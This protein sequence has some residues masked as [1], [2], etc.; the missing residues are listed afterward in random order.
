MQLKTTESTDIVLNTTSFIEQPLIKLTA[1]KIKWTYL[2]TLLWILTTFL[3]MPAAEIRPATRHIGMSEGLVNDFVRK[4]HVDGQ[5][6]VWVI[7]EGGVSVVTGSGCRTFKPLPE[8]QTGIICSL[9]WHTPTRS[10]VLGAEHG[11][12]V[13]LPSTDKA[14]W[15]STEDG[16]PDA[17][18]ND[19]QPTHGD[20]LWLGFGNGDVLRLQ[21]HLD[22]DNVPHIDHS[23]LA[24]GEHYQIRCLMDDG[25]GNLYIGHSQNGMSVVSIATGATT[26]YQHSEGVASSLPG[27]NVR[28]ILCDRNGLIW[29][30]TD[31]GLALFDPIAET[32]ATV[33][34]P[35]DDYVDNV[36]DICHMSNNAIL[37]ATDIGGVK[38]LK[39]EISTQYYTDT[40]VQVSS[41]NTR[42]I[43][44]D[45]YGNAWIGCYSSGVDFIGVKRSDFL[46][47]DY[48]QP[49]SV[50]A[51]DQ[52]RDGL[53]V[54]S[55]RELTIWKDNKLVGRWDG[56]QQMRREYVAARCMMVDRDGYVWI[57]I[58]DVGAF[59]I[60]LDRN[61]FE[62]IELNAEGADIHSFAQD[63]DG[64]IW[65][66]SESGIF[67]YMNG[68]AEKHTELS[69][70]TKSPA[71]YILPKDGHL[72]LCTYGD[73]VYSVDLNTMTNRHLSTQTG[74][75]SDIVNQ[76]VSDGNQGMWL[77]TNGGLVRLD[78]AVT[79]RG[80]HIY[81]VDHGLPDPYVQAV[82]TDSLNHVW[83]TTYTGLSCLACSRVFYNFQSQDT[84]LNGGFTHGAAVLDPDG[85]IY[86]GSASGACRVNPSHFMSK[87]ILSDIQIVSCEACNIPNS[88]NDVAILIPDEHRMVE[89]TYDHNTLRLAY[90]VRNY[91]QAR[92]IDYSYM[93]MG[94]EDKW[95][96]MGHKQEVTFRGL[97]PG[98]YTFLVRA[99]MRGQDNP[100]T[101]TA[102][103]DIRVTPPLWQ[104]WW[105]YS[106]YALVLIAIISWTIIVYK[107]RLA[108]K[109]SLLLERHENLQNKLLNEERMRFYTNITHELRTPLTLI[110]GPLDDLADD[111]SLPPHCHKRVTMI[112][113]SAHRLRELL[114]QLLDFRKAETQNRRL[115][116]AKGDIGKFVAEICNNFQTLYTNSKVSF[117]YVIGDNLPE[118]WFDSEIV[119]SI[120]NN[121]LSNAIKYTE[122]GSILTSVY[123]DDSRVTI[124][125]SD[126]GCGIR[127]DE[128]PHIF[129]RYYQATSDRQ[130]SGTGIGL[131]LVKALAKLHNAKLSV[132]SKEG[133]GSRFSCSFLTDFRYPDALHKEDIETPQPIADEET[134]LAT[135]DREVMPTLLIVED[136]AD[137]RQYIADSFVDDYHILQADNGEQGLLL[138][139]QHMPDIIVS[140]IMMPRLNGIEMTRRLKQ[141]IRTSHIPIIILTAKNTDEDKTEGYNCGADSYLTKPFSVNLLASR[142]CNLLM[143]RRRIAEYVSMFGSILTP[144][145]AETASPTQSTDYQL[146][147]LDREFLDHLDQMLSDN[148]VSQDIDLPFISDKMGMSHSSFYRKV[149]ALTGLTA[150]EYIRKFKLRHC[151][152]LLESGDYN[153]NQAAMMTGFNQMS[154]FRDI[155][156]AEFGILPSEVRKNKES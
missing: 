126:T 59:R 29:V 41:L 47:L 28:R 128:L 68:K 84:H 61:R 151:Y 92:Q 64:R 95:Y 96:D 93:L 145:P 10:M 105:A 121:F 141:D 156:K 127:A 98:R 56:L 63:S 62:H 21:I 3:R 35:H 45:D 106:L 100:E 114:C 146:S 142:I 38:E 58:D 118:I 139:Q 124:S 109:S 90:S 60:D 9:N 15:F 88:P 132:D 152:K 94:M 122:Q 148:M 86:F 71:T 55:L 73:G 102:W 129:E 32:F 52:V 125:V 119:T 154:H 147:A 75:P 23:T 24:M 12:M 5:G 70:L 39:P 89:T 117:S 7:T 78:D 42:S 134:A 66:G 44:M 87:Q 27:N 137:I 20:D 26:N 155:F 13:F 107:R 37:V 144:T 149:K 4:L 8:S 22:E 97:N 101:K 80:L 17:T 123:A 115:T 138:A 140:D 18:L 133:E 1:M 43:D 103:L 135:T 131:A 81:G 82:Q 150:Q 130:A 51:Y 30:G 85:N 6:Y 50:M 31:H 54:A 111:P 65:I 104:S 110:L 46:K 67:T 99:Q 2:I 136:N 48:D 11:L 25:E 83:L 116:V 14:Y 33:K 120:V 74:L 72:F 49:V 77:A 79:L 53:L 69:R 34:H 108:L 143:A 91:A 112:Q 76:A 36:Y 57:G 153:V 19:I 40:K 16:L 113:R